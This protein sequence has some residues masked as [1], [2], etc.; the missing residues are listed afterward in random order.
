MDQLIGLSDAVD[1]LR[2][3]LTAAR[4]SGQGQPTLFE[5]GPVEIELSVV[6]KKSGSGRAGVNIGVVTIGGGGGLAREQT[7]RVKITL[8]PKDR[9]TGSAPIIND[10][11]SELP[12]D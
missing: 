10:V 6:V 3:E 9:S 11:V 5:V 12:P 7:H 2:R 1:A 8:T 4:Q